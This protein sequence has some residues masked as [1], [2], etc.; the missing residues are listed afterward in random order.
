METIQHKTN[1]LPVPVRV[2]LPQRWARSARVSTFSGLVI[3]VVASTPF[4]QS[5]MEER[6]YV[7]LGRSA[8]LDSAYLVGS[9]GDDPAFLGT[10][11]PAGATISSAVAPAEILVTAADLALTAPIQQRLLALGFDPG[12][13]DGKLGQKT[14]AAIADYQRAHGLAATGTPS[15]ALLDH[16]SRML[17]AQAAD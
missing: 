9:A 8:A 10:D 3:L 13:V 17:V 15:P 1:S 6:S 14:R 7:E 16:L 5:P 2:R 12:P 4:G 11:L